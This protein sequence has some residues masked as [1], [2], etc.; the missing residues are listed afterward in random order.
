MGG[1]EEVLDE[2]LIIPLGEIPLCTVS[3]GLSL[4]IFLMDMLEVGVGEFVLLEGCPPFV[5]YF[6]LVLVWGLKCCFNSYTVTVFCGKS[7][8]FQSFPWVSSQS[9]ISFLMMTLKSEFFLP[10]SK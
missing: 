4:N 2:T 3:R 9:S 1:V 5:T 8:C 6:L 7:I 10:P